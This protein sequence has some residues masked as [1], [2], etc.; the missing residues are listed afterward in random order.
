MSTALWI[1]LPLMAIAFGLIVGI[2]LWMVLR[3]PDWHGERHARTVPA[4]LTR[5][6]APV[7]A[8]VRVPRPGGYDRV[9]AVRPVARGANG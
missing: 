5:G 6:A 1:N 8:T 9:R 7:L 4:Y 2:P 3:R